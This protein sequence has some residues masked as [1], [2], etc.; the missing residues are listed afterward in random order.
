MPT[1]MS[2]LPKKDLEWMVK[3]EGKKIKRGEREKREQQY[4]A[5]FFTQKGGKVRMMLTE[6]DC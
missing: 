4:V 5:Q 6:K 2:K 1:I 3:K